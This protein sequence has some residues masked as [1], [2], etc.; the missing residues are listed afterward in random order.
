MRF[1]G[2]DF[3]EL[4]TA[5]TIAAAVAAGASTIDSILLAFHTVTH[6]R[7]SSESASRR[8]GPSNRS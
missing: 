7:R 3:Q 8:P 6:H 4:N 1:D 5:V 2:R